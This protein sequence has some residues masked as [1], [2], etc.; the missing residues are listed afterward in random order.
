[1]REARRGL[2]CASDQL[3][4][5]FPID[6]RKIDQEHVAALVMVRDIEHFRRRFHQGFLLHDVAAERKATLCPSTQTCLTLPA[7]LIDG[8]P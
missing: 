3:R 2:L 1:M 8:V 6:F 7:T 5:G 4:H